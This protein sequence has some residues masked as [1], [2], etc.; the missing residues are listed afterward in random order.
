MLLDI[1]R[2]SSICCEGA[3]A[4]VNGADY[5]SILDLSEK[6]DQLLRKD[7]CL[8]CW[9]KVS[10]NRN[11]HRFWRGKVPD[12]KI[13]TTLILDRN[14]KALFLLKAALE[15]SDESNHNEAFI[16]ALFLARHK[17]LMLR[18]ELINAMGCR[19]MIYEIVAT[20][21]MIAVPKV[22]LSTIE[23]EKIQLILAQKFAL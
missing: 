6:G 1:P 4:F 21:E 7:Y 2:R 12:K 17:K 3:E 10:L 15:C 23:T 20:E 19:L 16:L 14:E 9:Q 18:Q 5:F 8:S 11:N 22:E 13:S